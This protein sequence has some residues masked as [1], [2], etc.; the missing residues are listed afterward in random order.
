[1]ALTKNQQT[2]QDLFGTHLGREAG[3]EGL[4][5]WTA[6][7]DKG[8]TIADLISGIQ[9]GSEWKARNN[10][11]EQFGKDNMG[12]KP[13]EAYLDA[14]ISP[15]GGS[16]DPNDPTKFPVFAEDNEWSNYHLGRGN[17]DFKDEL[18]Q[19]YSDLGMSTGNT[20]SVAAPNTG[21]YQV[22]V[23]HDAVGNPITE[24]GAGNID[25]TPT[26]G[27]ADSPKP[28]YEGYGS[29]EEWLADNPQ[30]KGS[31]SSGGMDDFFKFMMFMNM[32][33]PQGVG[34]GGSQYG[35]GGLNPGGVMSAYNPMD[36][37]QGMMDAFKSISTGLTNTGT[38]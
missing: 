17:N 4:D 10:L 23:T 20:N 8:K 3:Q 35:Y 28:W 33:R 34:Y 24:T 38:T 27:T 37:M 1:M 16:L 13:S 29:G 12:S 21:N 15:G 9:S 36:N 25:L 7:L 32:M 14:R 11:V 6:E 18:N 31:G 22:G 30:D 19:V 5:Y 2:V 26:G